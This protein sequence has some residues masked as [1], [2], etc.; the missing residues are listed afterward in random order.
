MSDSKISD[1]DMAAIVQEA[2]NRLP[3][4]FV[5]YGP[6]HEILLTNE[7]NEIDFAAANAALREGC[8]YLESTRRGVEAIL[9]HL[10]YEETLEIAR[11]IVATLEGGEPIELMT[12]RGAI[13]Q[14]TETK[15]SFGGYVAVGADVTGIHEREKEL[16][17]ARKEAE[18]AN[19][20]KSAFLANISHE[21]RTP[22]NGILG[23]AQLMASS[24]LTPEQRDQLD[25]I[26]DSGKTL[27]AI[28]N[29]VLD[30]SKIEAGKFDISP[31]DNDLGHLLRRLEKLWAPR[32]IE[33]GL[34]L[35]LEIDPEA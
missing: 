16:R 4:G 9:S 8:T 2:V 14:V 1:R 10:S 6:D 21:I 13:L 5:V 28:L 24:D 15:L 27:M 18:A 20:A 29:D 32:A 34:N 33:K 31:I 23:M 35:K 19:D 26:L 11:N 7:Q 22:L 30:L 17:K 25:T 12:P 3:G